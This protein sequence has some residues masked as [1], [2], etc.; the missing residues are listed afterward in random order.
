MGSGAMSLEVIFSVDILIHKEARDIEM[1]SWHA[2]NGKR[3][4]RRKRWGAF[5]L[6]GTIDMGVKPRVSI[7]QA[8]FL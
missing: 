2:C 5:R 4:R 6:Q 8:I 7:W 3:G 1:G